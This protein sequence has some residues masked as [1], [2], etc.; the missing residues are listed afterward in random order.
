[1]ACAYTI[2]FGDT[3]SELAHTFGGNV[4]DM[5]KKNPSIKD[6]NNIP[7]GT[8]ILAPC[9]G[10]NHYTFM[11]NKVK[12]SEEGV[13]SHTE[14]AEDLE[15]VHPT[16]NLDLEKRENDCRY[17]VKHGDSLASIAKY[18]SSMKHTKI[19]TQDMI[20]ANILRDPD[21]IFPGELL[22]YPGCCN[23]IWYC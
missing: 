8:E 11:D 12:R 21:F 9:V 15:A 17:Q 3:L 5:L 10:D 16:V 23:G 7:V 2:Q 6:P 19:S 18:L 1:M 22:G 20:D 4:R 13:E 14:S